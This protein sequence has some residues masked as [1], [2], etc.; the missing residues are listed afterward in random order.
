[1]YNRE[2]KIFSNKIKWKFVIP[3]PKIF[4]INILLYTYIYLYIIHYMS[5]EFSLGGWG[6]YDSTFPLNYN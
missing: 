1:M 4:T 3:E 5:S 6:K 2:N